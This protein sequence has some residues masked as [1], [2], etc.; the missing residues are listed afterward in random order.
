MRFLTLNPDNRVFFSED[1][2]QLMAL[3]A[4]ENTYTKSNTVLFV[5]APKDGDVFTRDTLSAIEE[6]TEASWLMPFSS[7]VNSITNFQ[8]KGRGR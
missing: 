7:R 5:L 1:N 8:H 6:L 3:E 4:L 2:P